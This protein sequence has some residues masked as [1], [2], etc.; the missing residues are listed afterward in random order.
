MTAEH[1]QAEAPALLRDKDAERK[2]QCASADKAK[3]VCRYRSQRSAE[4]IALLPTGHER[5]RDKSCQTK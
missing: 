2:G 4:D 1:H 5:Q 3:D